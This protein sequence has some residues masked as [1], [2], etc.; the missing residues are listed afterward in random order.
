M[1]LDPLAR[2]H[3]KVAVLSR[4]PGPRPVFLGH[5]ADLARPGRTR[6]TA[7]WRPHTPLTAAAQVSPV[8]CCAE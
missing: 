1:L 2:R 8:I 6:R 7:V 5:S 3:S 4:L